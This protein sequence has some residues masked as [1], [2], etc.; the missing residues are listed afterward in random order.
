MK[1]LGFHAE[2]ITFKGYLGASGLSDLG[3]VEWEHLTKRHG[4]PCGIAAM[5]SEEDV[6]QPR[7]T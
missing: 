7:R 3:L 2:A 4:N 5:A 1:T 6:R